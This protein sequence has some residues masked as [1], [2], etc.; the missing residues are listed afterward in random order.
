MVTDWTGD[1]ATVVLVHNQS[2]HFSVYKQAISSEVPEPLVVSELGRVEQA[3]VSP[4]SKWVILQVWPAVGSGT[5]D[6]TFQLMRVPIAGGPPQLIFPMRNGGTAFCAR[7][8]SNLC[9]VAEQAADLKTMT[10]TAFDPVNGRGAEL[11]R[12]GLEVRENMDLFIDG[13]LL[14]DIAP[15]GTRLAFARSSDGPIEIHS[16]RGGPTRIISSKGL[17]HLSSMT[18][19]A[20]GKSLFVGRRTFDAGELLHVDMRG[21]TQSLWKTNGGR[22]FAKPS[23]D[24]S[25]VAIFDSQRSANMWMIENF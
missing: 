4:D 25:H 7:P 12:F 9:A 14:C 6:T 18:W 17:D 5:P 16:L 22:C 10:V 15:D 21:E 23:P 19:A 3:F 24:G 8:P 2:D 20:D 1:S 11:A 13:L